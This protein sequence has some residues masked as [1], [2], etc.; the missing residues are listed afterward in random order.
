MTQL[1]S[2]GKSIC[3]PRNLS[4]QPIQNIPGGPGVGGLFISGSSSS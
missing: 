4:S 2:N 1:T 3:D